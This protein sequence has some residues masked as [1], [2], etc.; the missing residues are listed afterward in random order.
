[1]TGSCCP[2][3]CTRPMHCSCT[4][5]DQSSSPNTATRHTFCR[6]SRPA[7]ERSET[8]RMRQSG[9][10]MKVCAEASFCDSDSE[11]V[12]RTGFKSFSFSRSEEHTSELQSLLRI[13]YAVFCL[14]KKIKEE[15][16]SMKKH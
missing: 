15:K 8:M 10:F 12:Y 16:I 1:M 5:G 13:S 11:P 9:S 6:P 14:K 7:P 3:R 2:S 4:P